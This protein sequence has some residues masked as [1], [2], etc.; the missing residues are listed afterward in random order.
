MLGRVVGKTPDLSDNG[1]TRGDE[2]QE[3]RNL[4]S[5]DDTPM[6]VLEDYANIDPFENYCVRPRPYTGLSMDDATA[7][8]AILKK[9]YT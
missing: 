1:K 6:L 8:L 9:Q 7:A 5:T 3:W 4:F 2:I